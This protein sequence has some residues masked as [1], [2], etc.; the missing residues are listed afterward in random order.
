MADSLAAM[1]QGFTGSGFAVS[2]L[3]DEG[4]TYTL[5]P[6]APKGRHGM[7][8]GMG[9]GSGMGSGMANGM[10]SGMGSGVDR[11]MGTGMPPAQ[12]CDS[13]SQATD[14]RYASIYKVQHCKI[15]PTSPPV[16][17]TEFPPQ[18]AELCPGH[19][20]FEV[21]GLGSG[22]TGFSPNRT[23]C[24]RGA[25][26]CW[27]DRGS[28][29][30]PRP[31]RDPDA[32][33]SSL[34]KYPPSPDRSSEMVERLITYSQGKNYTRSWP[35]RLPRLPLRRCAR[36]V[37]SHQ[38][39]VPAQRVRARSHPPAQVARRIPHQGEEGVRWRVL[40]NCQISRANRI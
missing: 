20:N 27:T 34:R 8:N 15:T 24:Y 25:A 4:K 12:R 13:S 7:R 40:Q 21:G 2:L 33:A 30:S 9:M 39:D 17:L 1:V 23:N 14:G 3:D 29:C 37:R 26:M 10:G 28:V 35:A 19:G 32:F 18:R 16:Q 22:E 5:M 6:H 36:A 31:S 38:P 11:G